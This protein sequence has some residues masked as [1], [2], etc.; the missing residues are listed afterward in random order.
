MIRVRQHLI[1]GFGQK[2]EK[3]KMVQGELGSG[4]CDTSGKE[5]FVNDLIEGERASYYGIT[6]IKGIVD[7]GPNGFFVRELE[8]DDV[9]A[10]TEL[11]PATVVGQKDRL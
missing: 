8:S 10:L 5:I 11:V 6:I 3:I 1:N 9:Y 2:V 7:F 4:I